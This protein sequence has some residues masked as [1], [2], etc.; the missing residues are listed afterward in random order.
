MNR[1]FRD[2]EPP[3]VPTVFAGFFLLLFAVAA[4]SNLPPVKFFHPCGCRFYGAPVCHDC[5]GILSDDL[6]L[7]EKKK[8]CVNS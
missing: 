6:S 8:E 5:E 1:F 4:L 7:G 2:W 3:F